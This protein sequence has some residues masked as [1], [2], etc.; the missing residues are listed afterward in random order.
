MKA[1]KKGIV[2][3]TMAAWFTEA[4]YAV[5]PID[6]IPDLIPVLGLVDDF[7]GLCI[8][9]AFTGYA[10]Y[11]WQ[12]LSAEE[13]L[14]QPKLDVQDVVAALSAQNGSSPSEIAVSEEALCAS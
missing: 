11:R 3:S 14:P 2:L 4:A 8:V 1:T 13:K 10:F 5:S 7:I 9:L 12:R 6:L